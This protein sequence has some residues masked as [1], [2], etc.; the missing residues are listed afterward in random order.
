MTA[1]REYQV[2]EDTRVRLKSGATFQA[3]M[4]G[5][6]GANAWDGTITI[7]SNDIIIEDHN[8]AF[9]NL[10]LTLK[11]T[12]NSVREAAAALNGDAA[13]STANPRENG[14]K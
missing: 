8:H 4:V 9:A 10:P 1:P 14:A 12:N 13:R 5:S 3:S 2:T 11:D 7:G 6:V